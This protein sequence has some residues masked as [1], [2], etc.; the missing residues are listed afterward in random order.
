MMSVP[1]KVELDTLPLQR[2]LYLDF[3]SHNLND[4]TGFAERD[5]HRRTDI[6]LILTVTN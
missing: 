1:P 4:R 5:L 2:C 6:Q 3:Y